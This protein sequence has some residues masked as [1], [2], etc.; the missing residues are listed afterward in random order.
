MDELIVT[1]DRMVLTDLGLTPERAER[2]RALVEAELQNLLTGQRWPDG[3]A[4]GGEVHHLDAPKMRP[5]QK[6]GDHNLASGI[7]HSIAQALRGLD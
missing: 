2:I 5:A 6:R 4:S 1:I 7:A 3:L